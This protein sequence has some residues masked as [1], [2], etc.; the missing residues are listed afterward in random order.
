MIQHERH[1]SILVKIIHYE[2]DGKEIM[3]SSYY[4]T[5]IKETLQMFITA[6]DYDLPCNFNE[7]SAV[8]D[9]RFKDLEWLIEDVC[10]KFGSTED[11]P[12][13][14]VII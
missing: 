7:L 8:V 1:D 6:R 2:E 5:A 12:V 14:E 13:I 3:V 9:E 11:I 4:T 10:L